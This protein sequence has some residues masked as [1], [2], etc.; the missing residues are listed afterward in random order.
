MRMKVRAPRPRDPQGRGHYSADGKAWHD[1]QRAA[2]FPL[3]E[4]TDVLEVRLEDVGA[5]SWLAGLLTVL[6]SQNGAAYCRFT[7][8]PRAGQGPG[9]YSSGT[10][11]RVRSLPDDVPPREEWTP[12][13]RAAL[14][15]LTAEL[16]EHGWTETAAR[17]RSVLLFQR[18]RPDW[19][20]PHT[21]E[22]TSGATP[23]RASA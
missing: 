19:R 21:P 11:S 14:E 5:G 6:S 20:R 13:M 1:D 18:R 22:P 4:V 3:T 17:D 2:W 10:F 12:G 7:A 9:W 8:A 16:R 23:P 15:E